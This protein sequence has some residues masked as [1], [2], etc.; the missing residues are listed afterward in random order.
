MPSKNEL[1]VAGNFGNLARISHFIEQ[2]AVQ[3]GLD[4]RG[5]YAMQMAVDEACTNI[6]EHAYGGEDKGDL[7]LSCT[8]KKDG[9]QVVIYDQG[10][11][12]DPA[13]VPELNTEAPLHERPSGGMGLF[14]IRNLV[15]QVEFRFGT[16]SG[17]Q[18]ILFK[19]R[20]E[21]A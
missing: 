18:L 7:R 15:D 13:Q 11:P 1:R 8:I 6:I 10:E 19:R 3:A 16:P 4:D 21:S 14:F 9:L 12:F 17:N 2:A 5:V 20:E